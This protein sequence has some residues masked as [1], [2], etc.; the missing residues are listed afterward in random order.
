MKKISRIFI[1]LPNWVGDVCMSLSSLN[2]VISSKVKVVICAKPWAESLLS[3]YLDNPQVDFIPLS[4]RWRLDA[5][6]IRDYRKE[7]PVTDKEVGLIIPDSLTSALCFKMAGLS[8]AGYKDD[9]RS[10][11]LTWPV[12]KIKPR[13]HN[14]DSWH[15]LTRTALSTWGF[16][17][18]AEAKDKVLLPLNKAQIDE[19][20][21]YM[22]Q[23]QLVTGKFIVIAPTATGLHKG[24]NKVW[25][26]Y[27][28]LTKSL[29][30]KGCR[31]I[32]CPP[33][34]EATQAKSN[35]PS[36]E[37]L[38]PLSLGAYTALLKDAALVICNDS[39]VSHL[40]AAADT[41]QLTL[42]GTTEIEH[43][44]PWSPSAMLLG[45]KGRWPEL[46]EVLNT[47]EEILKAQAAV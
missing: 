1:R 31:V 25:D 11:L 28:Q 13:P 29:K 7:H 12:S 36:A 45:E 41:Q 16:S 46:N 34:N 17:C 20:N 33:T 44:A 32:M 10:L 14:V 42:I 21:A 38:P 24:K 3:A 5:Q 27:E 9:G 23:H 26:K 4:G 30:S 39:G 8:S 22:A 47:A 35:A 19:K 2:A 6:K 40:S 15:H 18:L 43:T 37:L